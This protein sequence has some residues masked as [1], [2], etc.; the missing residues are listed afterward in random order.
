[1]TKDEVTMYL[2][3]QGIK[4]VIQQDK[5]LFIGSKLKMEMIPIT[6]M[7]WELRIAGVRLNR[8]NSAEITTPQLLSTVIALA[9]DQYEIKE[10]GLLR[11]KKILVVKDKITGEI[12]VGTLCDPP[13][14]YDY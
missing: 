7:V 2:N 9:N 10:K 3:N 5:V 4:Y 1:M 8:I 12:E 11:K 14:D 6:D 13:N